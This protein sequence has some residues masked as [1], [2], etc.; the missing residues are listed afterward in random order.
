MGHVGMTTM[1][2]SPSEPSRIHTFRHYIRAWEMGTGLP[3]SLEPGE[4]RVTGEELLN[5]VRYLRL[6][7][8]FRVDVRDLSD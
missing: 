8:T 4:Y 6:N 1:S 3:V 7:D 2:A 5:G